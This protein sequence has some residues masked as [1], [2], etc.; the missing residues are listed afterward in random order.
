MLAALVE[1]ESYN[2]DTSPTVAFVPGKMNEDLI[3]DM[4]GRVRRNR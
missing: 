3:K 1:V 4:I 2:V